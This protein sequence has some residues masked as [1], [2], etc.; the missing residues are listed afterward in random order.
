MKG[1]TRAYQL[2][3]VSMLVA[4]S[5]CRDTPRPP[6]TETAALSITVRAGGLAAPDSLRPGWTRMHV[7]EGAGRHIVVAFRMPATATTDDMRAFVAALDSTPATPAPGVAIGGPEMGSRGDV[8]VHL[9]PGVYVVACVS[10]GEDGHRHAASGESHLLHVSA[11]TTADTTHAA[12]P[13]ATQEV[14][15]VNFAYVGPEQWAPGTQTLR[16][17][18]T[19]KQDHQL[20][21]AR[22]RDGASVQAWMNADDPDTVAT[23]IAGMA[24]VGAGEVAYLPIEFTPGT[25]VL[26]CLVADPASK[27]PHIELGMLRVVHV[28]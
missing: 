3:V 22:L 2:L 4:L 6:A 11:A 13:P 21:L 23:T 5:A 28:P 7:Y 18:N 14:R 25:Y 16:L 12:P 15:L 27:R 8:F 10:R 20:R 24:R 19:G 1:M 9:T 17:E 26:Y